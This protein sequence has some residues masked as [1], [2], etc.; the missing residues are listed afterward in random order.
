MTIASIVAFL[1]SL[2]KVFKRKTAWFALLTLIAVAIV[3]NVLT[4][5]MIALIDLVGSETNYRMQKVLFATALIPGLITW[6]YPI[7]M[8]RIIF[9]EAIESGTYR[10]YG[11]IWGLF[12]LY[13]CGFFGAV[14]SLGQLYHYLSLGWLATSIALYPVTF[15]IAPIYLII[16]GSW[17]PILLNFGGWLIGIIIIGITSNK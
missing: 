12:I 17:M 14:L 9:A 16:K 8:L 6:V 11:F 10:A 13:S 1:S 15:L 2:L 5:S 3:S 4:F 7:T